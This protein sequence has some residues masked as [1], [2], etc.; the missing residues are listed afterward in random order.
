LTKPAQ[1]S[2]AVAALVDLGGDIPKAAARLHIK[3]GTLGAWLQDPEFAGV[4]RAALLNSFEASLGRLQLG[5]EEA[6]ATLFSVMRS[7]AGKG[8]AN[9]LRAC[10]N[11]L[12]LG[13]LASNRNMLARLRAVEK[14]LAE[15]KGRTA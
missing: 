2:A 11:I 10:R 6:V 9:R 13:K 14:A 15:R 12:E 5:A 4:Y 8:D 1:H 3:A 7:G